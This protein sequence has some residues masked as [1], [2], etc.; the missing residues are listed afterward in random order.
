MYVY[1][2]V[3]GNVLCQVLPSVARV[4]CSDVLQGD[5]D[6]PARSGAPVPGD[7]GRPPALRD[8]DAKDRPQ[9]KQEVRSAQL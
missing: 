1:V 2:Y 6:F 3:C 7:N 8:H 5:A 9:V 4:S